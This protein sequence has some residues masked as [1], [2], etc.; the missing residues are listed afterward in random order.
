MIIFHYLGTAYSY[1][2][3]Q[4]FLDP[5]QKSFYINTQATQ[6]LLFMSHFTLSL[7]F[8]NF[9]LI[10]KQ[11]ISK[12]TLKKVYSL[13]LP[14]IFFRRCYSFC[15]LS[16]IILRMH[17][18]FQVYILTFLFKM[19]YKE[20]STKYIFIYVRIKDCFKIFVRITCEKSIGLTQL[21]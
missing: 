10:K 21:F 12:F 1:D 17:C 7:S 14:H 19:S 15:S 16:Y 3:A 20:R 13:Q 18:F 8:T 4:A 11:I 9:E 6:N 5:K 2:Q